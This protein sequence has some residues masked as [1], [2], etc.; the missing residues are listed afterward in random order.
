MT[1]DIKSWLHT[2]VWENGNEN[3]DCD[4][5]CVMVSHIITLNSSQCTKI[6][7]V[8]FVMNVSFEHVQTPYTA[9]R[10][11][12]VCENTN[13]HGSKTDFLWRILSARSFSLKSIP[14]PDV[15]FYLEMVSWW[16][17]PYFKA[18]F[19]KDI[20][21]SWLFSWQNLI[22]LWKR[23][24][25]SSETYMCLLTYSLF[26][27]LFWCPVLKHNSFNLISLLFKVSYGKHYTFTTKSKPKWVLFN[28][29]GLCREKNTLILRLLSN[30]Y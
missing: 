12:I 30:K 7:F 6:D 9:H 15:S 5:S 1:A 16:S 29:H 11:W 19:H 4:I 24:K 2:T 18:L 21:I 22:V 20:K 3:I 10:N 28:P 14:M 25:V 27:P 13:F 8:K 17:T 23:S 26:S